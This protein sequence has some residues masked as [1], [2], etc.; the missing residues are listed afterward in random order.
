MKKGGMDREWFELK[1]SKTRPMAVE[2][3]WDEIFPTY[4][5]RMERKNATKVAKGK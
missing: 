5:K 2:H 3:P 1:A 4:K